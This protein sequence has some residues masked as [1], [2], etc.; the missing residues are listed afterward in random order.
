MQ[1]IFESKFFQLGD[2]KLTIEQLEWYC[3]YWWV[4]QPEFTLGLIAL[5]GKLGEKVLDKVIAGDL[6]SERLWKGILLKQAPAIID[7][8]GLGRDPHGMMHHDL[9]EAQ[10]RATT[11]LSREE[12]FSNPIKTSINTVLAKK[13]RES[14]KS[15]DSGLAMMHIV[16]TISPE[17]F[18]VQKKIFLAA[19]ALP[20]HLHHSILHESLEKEHAKESAVLDNTLAYLDME[21]EIKID[22]S[23]NKDTAA[24]WRYFLDEIY[25]NLSK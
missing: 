21:K 14:F 4:I 9:F 3:R 7:E 16:E 13:I 19:G 18:K 5:L 8:M 11:R 15:V 6:K 10:V 25:E 12:L 20:L 17:L 24:L 22:K 23:F 2:K 1:K